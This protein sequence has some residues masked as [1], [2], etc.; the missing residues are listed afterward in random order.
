MNWLA[1]TVLRLPQTFTISPSPLPRPRLPCPFLA[2]AVPELSSLLPKDTRV[3]EKKQFSMVTEE[4]WKDALE[5]AVREDAA[6]PDARPLCAVLFGIEA[7]VCVQ[8]TALQMMANGY[9]VLIPVDGVSSQ[10]PG[11]REIAL[12]L[13]ARSGAHLT[14]TESLLYTLIGTADHPSFKE[15]SKLV[16]EH[17]AKKATGLLSL[18]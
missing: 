8:Q 12:E 18:K 17:N 15:L 3:Y 6:K 1:A 13:L 11:D 5:P 14:S 16:Q 10:R 4:V 2:L 9:R 7:H